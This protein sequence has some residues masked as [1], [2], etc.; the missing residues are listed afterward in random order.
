[1]TTRREKLRTG[2]LMVASMPTAD[3]AD[4][5]L[6]STILLRSSWQT[7]NIGDI[8]HTPGVLRLLEQHV[9]DT[10]V[11]LWPKS[12]DRGVAPMLR[13]RFPRLRIVRDAPQ[14]KNPDP[15]PNDPT[16][17]QAMREAD[18]WLHGSGSGV[19]EQ[20]DLERWRTTTG[21]PYGIF[22][23]SIGVVIGVPDQKEPVLSEELRRLLDGAAFVFTRETRSLAVLHEAGIRC[24]VMDF[25][26]DATFALDL[27][28][29]T[30]A[31]TF[32]ARFGLEPDQFLCAVPRLRITPYWDIVPNSKMAPEE[33]ARRKAINEKYAESDH[34]KLREVI[35]AW[36]RQTG[37]KV[38]LCPEMT[39]AVQIIRPLLYDSLPD[40]V[41][42]K[43][44]PM[45]RYWLTDEAA[46]VYRQSRVVVSMECHSPIIA[47]A[48]GRPGVYLRQPEDTW[49]GQMYL[50]LGLGDWKFEIQT[51]TGAEIA[52]R[53]LGIHSDYETS[54]AQVRK[55]AAKATERQAQAMA[56]VKSSTRKAQKAKR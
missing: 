39:Y 55:A 35:I 11:I 10:E 5:Q 46:S 18:L 53:V 4:Q 8:A 23:V 45:D 40:D 49:K 28:D 30:A 16:V 44:V 29:D 31:G 12:L 26:P 37:L 54:L 27:R 24:P 25:A 20:A 51:A 7:V 6:L 21:K 33:I 41:K 56:V 22:G 17:E 47:N 50:D 34:A 48:N 15:G 32:L 52:K 42:P 3:V 36:V 1:M 19:N 13:R 14:W 38:L 2:L 43:V 9:P